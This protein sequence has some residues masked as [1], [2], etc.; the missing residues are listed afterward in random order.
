MK[1][2]FSFLLLSLCVMASAQSVTTNVKYNKMD[3]PA[4]MLY[5]PYNQEVAEGTILAKLKEIGFEPE[6]KGSLFWKQNKVDGYYVYKGVVLKGEK[7]E[8]V[9]LYFKVDRRGNKRDNQSVIY[10]MTSKGAENFVTDASEPQVFTAAQSFL[11]GFVSETATYKHTLDVQAQEETVKKAE[12]KLTELMSEESD[13]TRKIAKLQED[14]AK[15]KQNQT[16]QQLTIE[17]ER[18]KLS[19]LKLTRPSM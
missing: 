7:N 18:K 14:L 10:M 17:G 1:T 8:L 16:T 12:K 15:N 5:L 4:L 11:N 2:L 3:K 9:D 19:D 6:S 13:L